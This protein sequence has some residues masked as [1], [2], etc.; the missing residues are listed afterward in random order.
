M[1]TMEDVRRRLDAEGMAYTVRLNVKDEHMASHA[2]IMDGGCKEAP[3]RVVFGEAE[4]EQRF[5]DLRFGQFDYELFQ[6]SEETVLDELAEDIRA[7]LSGK[8]KVISAWETCT[9][10][11]RGDACFYVAPGEDEDDS[12]EYA[13][14]V[15]RIERPKC[16]LLRCLTS[17]VTY[18]IYDWHSYREI[19]R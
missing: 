4:G 10:R 3:L 12:D 7:V 11:W 17:R 18:A 5:I 19:I 1:I 6:Y 8:T 9:H 15:R 16:R 2:I 14:A 13:A